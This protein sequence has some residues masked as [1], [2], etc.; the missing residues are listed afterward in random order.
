MASRRFSVEQTVAKLREMERLQGQ[1]YLGGVALRFPRVKGCRPDKCADEAD[2]IDAVR[3][4]AAD[5]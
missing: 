4:L 1:G 2:T 3:A 5:G